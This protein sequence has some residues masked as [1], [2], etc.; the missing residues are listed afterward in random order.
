M[1]LTHDATL[2][3]SRETW[4]LVNI[5][6]DIVDDDYNDEKYYE[7]VQQR[8]I[9]DYNYD[10]TMRMITCLLQNSRLWVLSEQVLSLRPHLRVENSQPGVL[11]QASNHSH[12]VVV[13]VITNATLLNSFIILFIIVVIVH[14]IIIDVY[15]EPSLSTN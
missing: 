10:N 13:I 15:Q 8:C 5:Y 1:Y 14:N 4:F 9:G 7:W 3:V 2:L 6:N 12:G 11:E